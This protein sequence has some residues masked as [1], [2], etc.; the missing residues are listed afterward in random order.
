VGDFE[1]ANSNR[2]GKRRASR[3]DD[4]H[5]RCPDTNQ[6]F[7]QPFPLVRQVTDPPLGR[8]GA[9]VA[10]VAPVLTNAVVELAL[11]VCVPFVMLLLP[12]M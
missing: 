7:H 5:Q 1:V 9:T 11:T 8:Q 6:S 4:R 12:A 2:V 10:H 3:N